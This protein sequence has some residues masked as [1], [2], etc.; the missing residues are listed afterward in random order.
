MRYR[1]RT[2]L[3]LLALGPPLLARGFAKYAAWKAERERLAQRIYWMVS[4]PMSPEDYARLPR[5]VG[6]LEA[7][8][9]GTRVGIDAFDK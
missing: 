5:T 7:Q 2:L 4:S 3:I 1:L 9:T 8:K 6:E